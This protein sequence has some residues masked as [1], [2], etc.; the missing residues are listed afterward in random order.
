MFASRPQGETSVFVLDANTQECLHYEAV[1]GYPV[2]E[3]VRIPREILKEHPELDI[4]NDLI[5]C[6]ID[7]C[8]PEV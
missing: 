7:V 6:G 2:Q 4:R 8:S 1:K 3:Y 5:D